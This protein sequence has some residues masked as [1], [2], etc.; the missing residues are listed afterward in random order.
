MRDRDQKPSVPEAVPQNRVLR[1]NNGA[2]FLHWL[3]A[4][5]VVAQVGGG[6]LFASMA[7]GPAKGT[8][9]TAHKTLG[10][11]ILLLGLARL[12]W[13]LANPPPPY[14]LE[15]PRWERIAGVWNHRAFY[16]LLV[17]LPLTG[18]TAI[19][20]GASAAGRTTTALLGGMSL[21]LIPGISKSAG[22]I[23]DNLHVTLVWTTLALLVLHI[24][25]AV[26][27][28]VERNRAAG[29]MPPFKTPGERALPAE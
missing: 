24:G 15:M 21:P 9:F 12:A 1:Y 27:H 7:N 16:F 4:L 22:E 10:A 18:L 25:A 17:A 19:S 3:T 13:R 14:P 29:R 26:K 23:A 8:V 28:Q 2:V 5:L 11:T 20:G 6:F